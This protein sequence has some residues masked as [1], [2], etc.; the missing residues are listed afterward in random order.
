VIATNEL[1]NSVSSSASTAVKALTCGT[2]TISDLDGN[3]YNIVV[4]GTQ[5]WTQTNLKVTKYNDGSPIDFDNTGGASG[6]DVGQAWSTRIAGAYTIYGNELSTGPNASTYGFLYN[7]YAATDARK[8]CPSGWHVPSVVEFN[9]LGTLL[10]GA[11]VAGGKMKSTSSLWN[12][13]NTGADNSSNF[14][15]V[16]GGMRDNNIGIFFNIG[17]GS[18]FWTSNQIQFSTNNGATG[19]LQHFSASLESGSRWKTAG[20]AVR[21]LKD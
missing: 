13:P 18:F 5:C 4:I 11:A 15:A 8:I 12:P 20:L 17:D 21:C 10:G 3:S 1:G 6:Y 19:Q 16:P 7:W 14:T 9:V 2:G